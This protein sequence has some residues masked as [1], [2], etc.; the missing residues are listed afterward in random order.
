[1]LITDFRLILRRYFHSKHNHSD[2]T[3]RGNML[4]N[5]NQETSSVAVSWS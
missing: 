3:L 4:L 2:T 5:Q 1:M